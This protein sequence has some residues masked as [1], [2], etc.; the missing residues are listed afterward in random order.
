MSRVVHFEIHATDPEKLSA[1]YA[2]VFGWKVTPI[3][4]LD[5]WLFD[6]G[7]GDGINGGMMKRMG[8]AS[9]DMQAVNAFVCSILVAS[10]DDAHARALEA[11][12][13]TALPKMAIPGIGYQSYI[14]DPD[15]NIVGLH[16]P[17]QTAH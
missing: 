1:F 10:V 4:Q 5:Y 17:D 6:T 16:Q 11:G 12:A 3:P 15:G 8:A 9:A 14:K 2:K 7:T 13:V